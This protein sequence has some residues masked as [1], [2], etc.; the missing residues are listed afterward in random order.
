V[1]GYRERSSCLGRFIFRLF[2][3]LVIAALAHA[4]SGGT[5]YDHWQDTNGWHGWTN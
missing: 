5:H 1:P 4:D 2:V 3:L